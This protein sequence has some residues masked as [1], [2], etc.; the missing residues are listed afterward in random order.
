VN[1]GEIARRCGASHNLGPDLAAAEPAGF[2]I[3]SRRISPGE[4]FIA[5]PGERADGHQF[6][7]EV[8]DK[9]ALSALVVHRR[10]PS[11]NALG[12]LADRLLFVENTVCALQGMAA[13]VLSE[14]G[15]PIVA[16]TGSAGKTTI[17]EL[18]S[19]VLSAASRVFKS[20]GNLNTAYGL[21]L[22]VARLVTGGARAADFD[23]GVF[24]MGMSSYGEIAR[25]V[26]IAPPEVGVVA[27]VGTAHLEF[28]GTIEGI[29]RAKAELVDGI[30]PGG[31]AILNADDA[32]V[33]AMASRRT[34]LEIIRF[35][36]AAEAEVMAREI[37]PSE[38]LGATRF[39]LVT[40]AGK[41]AAA[42]PLLGRHNLLNALAAAAVGHRFGLAP[43]AIAAR[44]VTA[45]PSPMRGERRRLG[46]GVTVIDDSY[47]SNPPALSSAVA[48]IAG[49]R[50]FT[51]RIVVA[52]E[53]LELG[54]SSAEL[55][56]QC[57][58]EI[59]R[60]GIDLIIGV[61][62]AARELVAA[63]A[64]EGAAAI[65]HE[66]AEEAGAWLAG[67][68]Q[69]GDLILV[70][71]RAA[72]APSASSRG[73]RHPAGGWRGERKDSRGREAGAGCS[74]TSSTSCSTVD[75]RRRFRR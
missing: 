34:D 20:E 5:L 52:G 36:L 12:A 57:G 40:P 35:G 58:R 46:N 13:H 33:A 9:G 73:W 60:L 7:R 2:A 38:D 64:A 10:L 21:P 66:T 4:L 28:F 41:A 27:N 54:V 72:Y 51:R 53:M 18:T 8:F 67:E 11:A 23:C 62:G 1:L 50:G 68:A 31:A 49:A 47:N 74:I 71:G 6:V 61:G 75:T 44:L 15:R 48:S 59:A 24:E 37:A 70:K 3:D 55:H 43:E 30:R 26:A 19:H 42:L 69:S 16:V 22:T 14:W 56:R 65:F 45:R 17:K 63:A 39:T 29:A 32:R 25:L